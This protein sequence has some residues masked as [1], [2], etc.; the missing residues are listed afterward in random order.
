MPGNQEKPRLR[1]GPFII[2]EYDIS[3]GTMHRAP[4]ITK[5]FLFHASISAISQV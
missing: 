4:T 1:L 5:I 2:H 3:R